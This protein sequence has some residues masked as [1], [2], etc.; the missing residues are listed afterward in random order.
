MA[1]KDASEDIVR[2]ATALESTP[3]PRY[4]IVDDMSIPLT[5]FVRDLVINDQKRRTI[6]LVGEGNFTFTV[7]LVALRGSG[8]E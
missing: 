6:Y 3:E 1:G 4:L 5:K 7:A 2:S 8:T